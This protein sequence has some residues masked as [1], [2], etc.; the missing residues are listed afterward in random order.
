[1]FNQYFTGFRA[2]RTNHLG[3]K[4]VAG[5]QHLHWLCYDTCVVDEGGDIIENF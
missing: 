2:V 3:A 1:M 5:L 4:R